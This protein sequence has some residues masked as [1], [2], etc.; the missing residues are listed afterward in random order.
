MVGK[1]KIRILITITKD[2]KTEL[3]QVAINENR[4]VA[5]LI[6]TILRKYINNHKPKN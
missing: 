2:M 4:T 1:D 3:E 6:V 5:N